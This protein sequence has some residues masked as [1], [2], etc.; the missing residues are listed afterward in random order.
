MGGEWKE[1]MTEEQSRR[2]GE[3]EK[4]QKRMTE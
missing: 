2:K 1:R 3:E 4:E